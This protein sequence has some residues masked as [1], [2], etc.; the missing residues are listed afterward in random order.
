[1]P[2]DKILELVEAKQLDITTINLANITGDFIKYV[3]G[4]EESDESK[5]N[6][7]ILADFVSV[8]AKLLLIKS[9][10]LLPSLQLTE[11]E[12]TDTKELEERLK[13]YKEFKAAANHIGQL[14][15]KNNRCHARLC[16]ASPRLLA[17][18]GFAV[19][20]MPKKLA[21]IQILSAIKYLAANSP[22]IE[23]LEKQEIKFKIISIKDKI[24]E[25]LIRLTGTDRQP[26]NQLVSQKSRGEVVATFLAILHLLGDKIIQAEQN[27]SFSEINI[28]KN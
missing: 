6:P 5:A 4:L 22:K 11:E 10:T 28:W 17:A 13:V 16:F 27:N 14:R 20:Y 1:M 23:S 21:A 26:F 9:K 15:G 3:Q 2:Y 25:I 7:R 18:A 8:A 19:F 24:K 12:E